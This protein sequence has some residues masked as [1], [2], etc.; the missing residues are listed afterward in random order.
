MLSSP[1]SVVVACTFML[2]ASAFLFLRAPT[3]GLAAHFKAAQLPVLLNKPPPSA[4]AS[5]NALK[6][7]LPVIEK[8]RHIG[9]T[10]GVSIGVLNHGEVVDEFSLGF[11]DR[12]SQRIA[13]PST[14]YP[15]G[16]LS[17]A[18]VATTVSELV[19]EGLLEW[20]KPVTAYLPELHFAADPSLADGLTLV[21]LLS[22]QTGLE[23]LDAFWLGAENEVLVAKDLTVAVIN[24]LSRVSPL[25]TKWMYN[26]WMYA[27]VG[28]VMERV[29]RSSWGTALQTRV[30]EPLQLQQTTVIKSRIPAGSTA[31]PYMITDDGDPVRIA[32]VPLLDGTTMSPAG[33]VR[34]SAHDMLIWAK[35]LM[36]GFRGETSPLH[37]VEDV[38]SGHAF[39]N[40]SSGFDELYALGLAKVTTPTQFGKMG[41]NPSLV[42]QMPLIGADGP[43]TSIFY[44]NGAMPGY[45]HCLMMI[46]GQQAAIIVLTNS[47]SRGDTADWIAQAILQALLGSGSGSQPVDLVPIAE[48]A[49]EKW[50]TRYAAMVDTL[51]RER[52]PGTKAPPP[53]DVVGSYRHKTGALWLDVSEDAGVLK[54]QVNGRESQTHTLQHYHYD[55]FCFLPS[56]DERIR[57]AMFHYTAPGFLLHFERE[58][59]GGVVSVKWKLGNQVTDGEVFAR[60]S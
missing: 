44:H 49:A 10:A 48:G 50:K 42:D 21:D 1:T 11:S 59:E 45:N 31:S 16:S 19:H 9:G 47:I 51:E 53:S 56:A 28:E 6:D 5:R 23:R 32:D 40:R 15:L 38:L 46:P 34:S 7:M 4:E 41:F 39:T 54:F 25:R 8:L 33:G 22:H 60:V 52:T 13:D 35:A 36:A 26:N 55:T 20:D 37:R 27:L 2:L 29:T 43:P 17:K 3:G 18:F 12:D 30:L 24:Q 57:R 14:R 58:G